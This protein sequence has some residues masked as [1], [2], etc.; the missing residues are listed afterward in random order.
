VTGEVEERDSL[1]VQRVCSLAHLDRFARQGLCLSVL[2]PVGE[3]VCL[4]LSPEHL[5]VDVVRRCEFA[6]EPGELLGLVVLAEPAQFAAEL[7]RVTAQVAAVATL[8]YFVTA[9]L[10]MLGVGGKG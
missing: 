8:L 2:T 3:N 1:P 10:E 5:C 9:S 6:T 7:R 4:Y